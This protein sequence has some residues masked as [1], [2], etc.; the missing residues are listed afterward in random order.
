MALA[1]GAPGDTEITLNEI[2]TEFGAPTDAGIRDMLAGGT[3]VPSGTLGGYPTKVP[4]PSSGEIGLHDF[5]GAFVADF[6]TAIITQ[7][8]ENAGANQGDTVTG[9]GVG[10]HTGS[11]N[12]SS[13]SAGA[14]GIVY[15][16]ASPPRDDITLDDRTGALPTETYGT[17][18]TQVWI[19]RVSE[20]QQIQDWKIDLISATD[21]STVSFNNGSD[22][23]YSTGLVSVNMAWSPLQFDSKQETANLTVTFR[24]QDGTTLS[25]GVVLSGVTGPISPLE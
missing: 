13:S 19:T 16:N 6:T 11:G 2:K 3:Y 9:V 15:R 8:Y 18:N 4:I 17:G 22:G 21:P 1:T 7:V 14:D 24:Y 5:Y 20:W 25:Q 12:I 10:Y 23:V